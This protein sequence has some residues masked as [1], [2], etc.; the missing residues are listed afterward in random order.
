MAIAYYL[1][2][3]LGF[4]LNDA[5]DARNIDMLESNKQGSVTD[6]VARMREQGEQ[7]R[8]QDNIEN[9]RPIK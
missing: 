5:N 4:R 7:M 8:K 2:D 9:G 1:F 3:R 6:I